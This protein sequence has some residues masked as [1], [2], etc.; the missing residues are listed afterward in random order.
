MLTGLDNSPGKPADY[1][2]ID[3]AGAWAT[4]E[5]EKVSIVLERDAITV[6]VSECWE[7]QWRRETL[8]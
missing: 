8:L 6:A 2:A 3:V 4:V 5:D 1:A 7:F